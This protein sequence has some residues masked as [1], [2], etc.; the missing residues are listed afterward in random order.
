VVYDDTARRTAFSNASGG[1]K[2]VFISSVQRISSVL[3]HAD[4][5]LAGRP[6]SIRVVTLR[7][8][9]VT[10]QLAGYALPQLAPI[11]KRVVIVEA[12]KDAGPEDLVH[13]VPGIFEGVRMDAVRETQ[14]CR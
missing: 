2:L 3:P 8:E 6:Q 9:V 13:K 10:Q 14:C 4:R 7:T 11:L 12:G 1:T 5:D